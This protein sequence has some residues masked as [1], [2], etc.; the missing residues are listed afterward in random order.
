MNP[1]SRGV[2][3]V[4]TQENVELKERRAKVAGIRRGVHPEGRVVAALKN[5]QLPR[6]FGSGKSQKGYIV[7]AF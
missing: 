2:R 5:S 4:H 6:F 7:L 3:E 1:E